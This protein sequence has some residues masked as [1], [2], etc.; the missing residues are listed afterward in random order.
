MDPFL[1]ITIENRAEFTAAAA[2]QNRAS[3]ECNFVNVFAWREVYHSRFAR[4]DGR[5]VVCNDTV[6]CLLFPLGAWLPPEELEA[7]RT[8]L[9]QAAGR[10]LFWGDVP[11]AYLDPHGEALQRFYDVERTEAEDDYLFRTADL[12][13]VPGHVHQNTRRLLRNFEADCPGASLLPLT[14][15]DAPAVLA[16]ADRLRR[17]PPSEPEAVAL[18]CALS[19]FS[20]LGLEGL[21]LTDVRG[22]WLAFSIW[23]FTTPDV[24]DI[25][26]EKADRNLGGAAQAIRIGAARALAGRAA[27]MNLEQDLGLPGLRRSKRAYGPDHLLPRFKLIPRGSGP[28]MPPSYRDLVQAHVDGQ[29]DMFIDEVVT[30]PDG[31]GTLVFSRRETEPMWN[32]LLA[33][34]V[35]RVLAHQPEIVRAFAA[36]GREPLCY[37]AGDLA[38]AAP[39]SWTLNG[40]NAWMCRAR[41]GPPPPL[42]EGLALR[43]VAT[44]E[45]AATFNRLYL[46]VFWG[47]TPAVPAGAAV[48]INDAV[49]LGR[50]AA[51]DIRHWLLERDG[52]A[53]ALLSTIRRGAQAGIYNV[54]TRPDRTRRG[55]ATQAI[56]AVLASI[57]REGCERTFLVTECN[58]ALAPF[59]ARLGYATVTKGRFYRMTGNG[60]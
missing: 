24:A 56:L 7:I 28:R 26:F 59:Y 20:E 32:V 42:P 44:P 23:S 22:N 35:G 46:D 33:D 2:I 8:R 41:G 58:P 38:D 19:H 52:E 3:C 4:Y 1:P 15:A 57:E 51:Y 54:G 16:L 47:D 31:A 53:V 34:D 48:P 17:G 6:G 27:W 10:P 18:A 37:L 39:P 45:A 25:H 50:A 29:R 12:A 14:A 9:S 13:A 49:A 5:L 30:A 11:Q 60:C 40:E 21:R 55:Y 43:R 36:R